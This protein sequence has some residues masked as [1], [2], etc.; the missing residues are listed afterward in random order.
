VFNSNAPFL[1]N[2]KGWVRN[3][4]A[5]FSE[6]SDKI[7]LRTQLIKLVHTAAWEDYFGAG[8]SYWAYLYNLLFGYFDLF[9][10]EVADGSDV[11]PVELEFDNSH[12]FHQ[13]FI[14]SHGQFGCLSISS[15]FFSSVFDGQLGFHQFFFHQFSMDNLAVHQFHQFLFHQ[16]SMDNLAVHQFHQLLFQQFSMDN[17]AVHQFHQFWWYQNFVYIRNP[18]QRVQNVTCEC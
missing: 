13:F 16:F 12:W 18:G 9:W 10:T 5:R 17:L 3:T 7:H 2:K 11:R 6:C 1:P 14:S 8:S 15:V 4:F